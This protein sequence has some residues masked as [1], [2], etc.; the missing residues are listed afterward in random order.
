MRRIA[1]G[2]V[3]LALVVATAAGAGAS[4]APSARVSPHSH[5]RDGRAVT[6][7]WKGMLSP[8]K[9]KTDQ[10]LQVAECNRAFTV[11]NASEQTYVNDCDE[12]HAQLSTHR[13][14]YEATAH[15]STV[16]LSSLP[17]SGAETCE[18]AVIAGH[19]DSEFHL[20]IER[21]AVAPIDFRT[22]T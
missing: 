16:G 5:L 22:A 12:Y 3:G 15:V 2:I 8:H 17:C 1:V 10:F 19:T 18:L 14:F 6:V 20:V 4:E 9:G 21:V 13:G 11:E 7:R